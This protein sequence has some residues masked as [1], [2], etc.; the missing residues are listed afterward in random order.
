MG[1]N[2]SKLVLAVGVVFPALCV[3]GTQFI[4]GAARTANAEDP[5]LMNEL[6]VA[7]GFRFKEPQIVDVTSR[8]IRSPLYTE[9]VDDIDRSFFV[10]I[11]EPVAERPQQDTISSVQV[12][13]ILPHPKNPL[14]IIDGK[15]RRVGDVLDSG[16]KVMS[17]NGEDFTVTLRHRSGEEVRERMKKN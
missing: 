6:R 15:P 10:D 11:D 3:F 2:Q 9:S 13:S 7:D 12:T 5:Q 8:A 14:A 4:G 16:W 1:I 17:I